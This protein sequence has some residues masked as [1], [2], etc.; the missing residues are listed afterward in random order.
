[1]LGKGESSKKPDKIG[2]GD[3]LYEPEGGKAEVEYAHRTRFCS[4]MIE[5]L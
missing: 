1:M 3:P 4:L 5:F 2:L